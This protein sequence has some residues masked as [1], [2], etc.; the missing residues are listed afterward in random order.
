MEHTPGKTD[1]DSIMNKMNEFPSKIKELEK[2]TLK[3]EKIK[4]I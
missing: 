2:R 1:L 4:L 3:I